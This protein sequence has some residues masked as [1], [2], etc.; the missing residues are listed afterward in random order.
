MGPGSPLWCEY[1]SPWVLRKE[2]QNII[3]TDGIET[4]IAPEFRT[5]SPASATIF[6]NLVLWLHYSYALP[7][8]FLLQESV[9]RLQAQTAAA[10]AATAA[11]SH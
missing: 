4:L 11:P 5:A 1:L 6:W 3:V 2:I 9:D 8:Q 7:V 10:A